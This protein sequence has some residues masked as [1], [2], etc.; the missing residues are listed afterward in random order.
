MLLHTSEERQARILALLGSAVLTAVA[1]VAALIVINPSARTDG[2]TTVNIA[3]GYV[4]Q[5][6]AGG[7]PVLLHGVR[8]GQVGAVASRADG[9]ALLAL[10]LDPGVARALTDTL[11]MDFRPANYFGITGVN[12]IP[13]PGGGAPLH[14]GATLA[15]T[16]RGNY[17]MQDFLSRV[18]DLAHTVV[19]PEL[20]A[21]IDRVTRYVDGLNPMLETLLLV[22][23]TVTRVQTVDAGH[24]VRNVA[25]IGVAAP[26][27]VE[28][29]TELGERISN[30]GL[31]VDEDFFNDHFLATVQLAATGL[32]G[33]VGTLLS[34]NV[35]NLLPATEVVQTMT[36][37]IPRIAATEDIAESLVELRTRFERMYEG[38]GEQRALQVRI[39]LDGLPGVAAPLQAMGATP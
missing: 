25:G 34:S 16:P 8:V 39:V 5:G 30:S 14:E 6:V 24:L 35:A 26:S 38:N 28:A 37:P 11:A 19:T 33:T 23:G 22:A 2:R 31:D 29:V 32:F 17:T 4:G 7:T 20:V 9:G 18:G 36:R 3:T 15:L 21:V 1:L 27:F 10:R 12:L 13:G